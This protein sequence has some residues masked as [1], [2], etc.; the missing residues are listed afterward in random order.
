MRT[1]PRQRSLATRLFVSSSVLSVGILL[2]AGII[3]TAV[4]RA[5]AEAGF[6]ERLG[7]YLRVL[8]AHLAA[9]KPSDDR[10]RQDQRAEIGH[11]AHPR[12]PL[13]PPT[14]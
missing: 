6:D 7:V 11:R 1:D 13:T 14:S 10:A 12:F 3:L 4:Y 5:S 2:I 8:V 9:D